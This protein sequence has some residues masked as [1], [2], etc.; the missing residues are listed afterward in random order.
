M[1]WFFVLE[2]SRRARSD[3]TRR[4]AIPALVRT[5]LS[6]ANSRSEHRIKPR[7]FDFQIVEVFCL[8]FVQTI[9]QTIFKNV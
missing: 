1:T 3:G 7:L 2:R 8:I 4:K 5:G 6:G 9:A